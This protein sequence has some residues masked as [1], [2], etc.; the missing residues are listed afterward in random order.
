MNHIEKMLFINARTVMKHALRLL[1][2]LFWISHAAAEPYLPNDPSQV[3][4]RAAINRHGSEDARLIALRTRLSQR[5]ADATAAATLARLYLE[6]ARTQSDPRYLGYTQAVLAPWSKAAQPPV[7]IQLLRA[8]AAQSLHDFDAALKDLDII[9]RRQPQH[10]QARLTRATVYQARGELSA[11][12][13]DCVQL[14]YVSSP[15]VANTCSASVDAL[16]GNA[17]RGYTRVAALRAQLSENE[18]DLAPWLDGLLAEFAQRTGNN[19]AAEQH[20]R[21]ALA[22][23]PDDA[24]LLA[25]FTDFLL[26][27]ARANEVVALLQDKTRADGLLLRLALAKQQLRAAETSQLTATLAARFNEARARG[28]ALHVREEAMLTLKLQGDAARAL[29]LAQE[30]WQAQR[31]PADARILLEAAL[32]AHQ[33]QGAAGVLQWMEQTRI[34]DPVLQTL[35][36]RLKEIPI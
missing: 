10:A 30:N 26:D 13:A 35:A 32:A 22:T 28:T 11:A 2:A 27:H 33:P 25:A 17:V 9:L 5:P 20:Y 21:A 16:N 29:E 15:L 12:R 3:L 7:E 18:R 14:Q 36:A 31:E 6:R 19:E 34:E 8:T 23:T 4:E 1:A 24:Y